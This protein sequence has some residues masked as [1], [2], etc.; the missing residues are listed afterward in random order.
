[1][2]RLIYSMIMFM[3][4]SLAVQSQTLMDII[5]NSPDHTILTAAINA[6]GFD[7]ALN[8]EN[9]TLTV[10]A[11]TDDAFNALPP[12]TIEALLED[13][14]GA[15][16]AVLSYHVLG[17]VYFSSD[18]EDGLSLTTLLGQDVLVT[19]DNGGVFINDAQVTAPDIIATNGVLHVI[20]AVLIPSFSGNT[21]FDIISNS[22]D[23]QILTA[24]VIAAGADEVL[25]LEDISLTLFAPTDEAFAALPP[26]T[27]EALLED[28]QGLLLDILNYHVLL[29]EV[30]SED[31]SDGQ[32]LTTALGQDVI[33][34]ID[35]NGVFVNN[36]QITVVDI[37]ASN[38]V[39]HVIDAVLIPSGGNTIYDIIAQSPVH[40]TLLAAID[41]TGADELL[42]SEGLSLTVFAP[43]DEAFDILPEGVLE[44]L[45]ADPD[46]LLSA[47]LAYHATLGA[48]FSEDLVDG[49]TIETALGQNVEVIINE[50]GVFINN[51]QVILADLEASNGVVHVIDAV[52]I[53]AGFTVMDVIAGS[54]VHETLEA[55]IIAAELDGFLSDNNFEFTVFA[56][57]DQAFAAL[58]PGT[59][60]ALLE[61]PTGA[62]ARILA[63]HAIEG[64]AFSSQ[65]SDELVIRTLLGQNVVVNITENGVF[66]NNAKVIIVDIV[67]TNGVVHVIDAVLL[68]AFTVYDVI[69]QSPVHNIL[70]VA[71]L[72]A[73]LEGALQGE[74]PFTVFAPTDQAFEAL[75]QEVIEAL[76]NDPS[77]DLTKVLLY[78]VLGAEVFSDDLSDG[79]I[80]E[81]LLGQDIS[82]SINEDG[83]FI[84]DAKVIIE[85]IRT[86]N[87][88]VHVI[89]A[90]LV[91]NLTSV[92]DITR[93]QLQ[94]SPNP[95]SSELFVQ[96][97][98]EIVGK[99]FTAR[100][101]GM[102]GVVLNS[103]Q[104]TGESVNLDLSRLMPGTY[105]LTIESD[106][107]IARETI[108]KK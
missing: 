71:I 3:S 73:D 107:Y 43:T 58:P 65:L 69:A 57:T 68:P 94:V 33:I 46:G 95:V 90:V 31:L 12:G 88:V 23:H 4:L 75:P 28:P 25:S 66:I 1:M 106:G 60:E 36:A 19:F 100:L 54:P 52:L 101:F 22:P 59:V 6:A 18:L 64:F 34:T 14:D 2:L 55:A 61:D 39:V 102:D 97:P 50:N 77:G 29:G 53:P 26:G 16:A 35:Q 96:I 78:H 62:L 105:I 86:L 30:Y 72:A 5:S 87:G 84:N 80:A 11:P 108:I 13:P 99:M 67:A 47:I 17:D 63:Y 45:V 42:K 49:Q 37:L 44:A 20:D 89:D 91:P 56:P 21:I 76:L 82:V 98:E 51:A 8:D 40:T 92:K 41:L 48:Y 9:L 70:D 103:W 27:I 85:D 38:G 79:Q 10:F 104:Q 24:A 32:I 81:T 15:L 7:A 83:I 74:G 93:L